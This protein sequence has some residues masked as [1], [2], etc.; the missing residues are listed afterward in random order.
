M[1]VM[2]RR[3][4]LRARDGHHEERVGPVELFFDLV[5]VFAVTQLSHFLILH[6]D[7]KG[8]LQ[9]GILFV[10]V[11]WVWVETAWVTNWLDVRNIE[12]RLLLF[13]L[14]GVAL[15]M[16]ISLPAAFAERGIIFVAT[17]F[18]FRFSRHFFMLA[19]LAGRAPKNFIGFIRITLWSTI[20]LV[21]WV[22]GLLAG[23]MA[24]RMALWGMAI[25]VLN[26]APT[27]AYWLPVM[28]ATDT[29]VWDIEGHHFSERCGLFIIIALGESI[30]VTGSAFGESDWSSPAIAAFASAFIS[31]LAMWWLYFDVGAERAARQLTEEA[32]PGRM[33]RLAYTYFHIP[34]V[35]GVIVTAASD[36]M[37]LAHPLGHA[38]TAEIACLIGGPALYLFGNLLFKRTNA[39]HFPLSHLVGLGLLALILPFAWQLSPLILS[40]AATATLVLVAG[41]EMRSLRDTRATLR[42]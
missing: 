42:D 1:G 9:A 41:W 8:F 30:L 7:P 17:Y 14:M 22:A 39:R 27:V 15:V 19:A 33:A 2:F 29:R 40:A 23:D 36:E 12:V 38:G 25:L 18:L 4:L 20:E 37:A 5:F 13:F 26:L 10:A 21:F 35:A 24:L 11:W 34:I 31:T 6:P 16:T 28:G 3:N 32:D